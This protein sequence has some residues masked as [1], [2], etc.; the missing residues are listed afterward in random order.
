MKLFWTVILVLLLGIGLRLDYLVYATYALLGVLL[1]S[2]F[3][4]RQGNRRLQVVR[5][6]SGSMMP[7]A[8]GEE[9]T[10]TVSLKNSSSLTI[11]WILFEES[12]PHHSERLSVG[13]RV[14]G[15]TVGMI[16]LKPGGEH[17]I[18]YRVRLEKRGFHQFGPLLL[19]TGDLF[20]LQRT[21]RVVTQPHFFLVLPKTVP[22]RGVR[23]VSRR[24]I[25]EIRLTHRLFE[26]PTRIASVRPYLPG[27][28]LQGI[29]WP[30]TARTGELHSRVYEPTCLSGATFLLD[31][32]EN[33]YLGSTGEASAELAVTIV[34]SLSRNLLEHSRQV[35]LIT[36]GQDAAG[37][38]GREGWTARFKIHPGGHPALSQEKREPYPK[39]RS[40]VIPTRRGDAQLNNILE[41]LGRLEFSEDFPFA[42]LVQE[43]VSLLPRDASVVPVLEHASPAAVSALGML[44]RKGFAVTVV[45]TRFLGGASPDWAQ[46]PDWTQDLLAQGIEIIEVCGE[47]G[48]AELSPE[49]LAR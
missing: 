48:L 8:I 10:V 7:N 20:G 35:G 1:L 19:E 9:R 45:Y 27:D 3:W 12:L 46:T 23:I 34:A 26:D 47:E 29:H 33:A 18:E 28:P 13:F 40:L 2:R 31:F 17:R 4:V 5:S 39:R 24:P 6:V 37:R 41:T 49:V 42:K 36:N 30:A 15:D 44:R 38:V 11:P 32:N 43:S 25:G 22:L 14:Y 21:I 16:R